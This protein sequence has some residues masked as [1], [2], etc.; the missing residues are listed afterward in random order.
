M[1]PL[2]EQGYVYIAQ[3]PLYMVRTDGRTHYFFTEKEWNDFRK[4]DGNAGKKLEPQRFKGLAEMNAEQLWETT[5]NPESRTMLRVDI[6]D[7]AAAD[8]LFSILMGSDVQERKD[9]IQ[10]NAKDVQNLDV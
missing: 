7:A 8:R 6:E 3:P 1:Q 2:I 9:F 10:Q 4:Q 5:M